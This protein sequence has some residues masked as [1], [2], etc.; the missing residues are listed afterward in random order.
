M[1]NSDGKKY[2]VCIMGA[3][4]ETGNMGVSALASSLIKIILKTKPNAEIKFLIGNKEPKIRNIKISHRQLQIEVINYRLSPK[5][6]ISEHLCWILICAFLQRVMPFKTIQD[7]LINKV[8]WLYAL[9]KADFVGNIHGGDSFSDIYGT[10][11]FII[12]VIP[13]LITLLM[14]KRL[15]LLP[16][17]YGPYNNIIA[18]KIA[19][20]ILRSAYK[21]Y[22]RD[23]YSQKIVKKMVG[24][25]K[26]ESVEFCPDVAF[27]LDSMKPSN[28]NIYPPI[29]KISNVPLIG[30]NINGL[31][32]MGGFSHDDMFQLKLNYKIFINNLIMQFLNKTRAHILIVPHTYD[33]TGGVDSDPEVCNDVFNSMPELYKARIHLVMENYNQSEIKSIINFCDFFIGSRMHACIAALSQGIPT[34]AVAYSRKF[35]GV[36]ES[37]GTDDMVIDAR[38][39]DTDLAV[40]YIFDRFQNIVKM[41]MDG[42]KNIINIK[43]LIFDKCNHMLS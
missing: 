13:D 37:I 12:G 38:V 29:E 19:K 28:I 23:K 8:P 14:R 3:S 30:L 22:S 26:A 1:I 17:T 21:I 40:Q 2:F 10:G 31:M 32:Y 39:T 4:F 33:P 42:N 35:I 6:K 11:R 34:M 41:K 15:I 25:K 7:K 5:A 36:F 18:R 20:F 27:V 9:K 24:T 16:Q 43:Q